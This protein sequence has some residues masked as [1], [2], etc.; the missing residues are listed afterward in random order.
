[1][2]AAQSTHMTESGNSAAERVLYLFCLAAAADLASAAPT[3]AGLGDLVL[4]RH[5]DLVAVCGWTEVEQWSGPQGELNLQDLQWLGPRVMH[6][7]AV[8]EAAMR[9]CGSVAGA[10]R[11]AVFLA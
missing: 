7:Q 11:H 1:M 6:H 8:I 4:H 9:A 10:S 2:S 5:G 3:I